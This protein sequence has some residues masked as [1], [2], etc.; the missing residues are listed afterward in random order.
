MQQAI[1]RRFATKDAS[2]NRARHRGHVVN[3]IDKQTLRELWL[4]EEQLPF[5]GWDFSHVNGRM[6]EEESPWDYMALAGTRMA[7]ATA[8]LDMDTGGG[9]KLLSL[10]ALWPAKVVVTEGYPPNVKL[11]QER[12]SLLGV[13]VVEMNSSNHAMTPFDDGEFDLILNR[14]GAFNANEVARILAPGGLFLTQQVHGLWAHSL[15]AHFGAS[16]QWPHATYED[17][18]TRLASA[19][20]ELLQGEDWQGKLIFEDV[21]AVVYTLKAI[22]WLVP[23]FSVERYFDQLLALQEQLEYEGELVYENMRYWIEARQPN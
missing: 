23:N 20:L 3:E 14:H 9:E 6:V 12:L 21:G 1:S 16:P 19:G 2:A 8:L 13:T 22:P 17:A 10:R 4:E 7:Q 15:I 11:L 5:T 18:I